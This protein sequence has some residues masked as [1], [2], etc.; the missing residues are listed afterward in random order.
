MPPNDPS[1][2]A[3]ARAERVLAEYLE[4]KAA[5]QP[6]TLETVCAENPSIAGELRELLP[7]MDAVLGELGNS[8]VVLPP[9]APHLEHD[10]DPGVS[11]EAP[12]PAAALSG[13]SLQLLER[14][15]THTP[16][17]SRYRV[18]EEVGSG[19]MGTVYR[20]WDED[21]R[22]PLA[23]KVVR[24]FNAF[25][26]ARV[27]PE[28]E[29]ALAR[30]LEEAQIT[31]QLDHPGIVPVHE[32]GL[33]D[34]GRPYFTM[35]LVRGRSL[36]EVFELVATGEEGWSETRA[37]GVLLRVCE[38][39]AFAHSKKVIHRDLKPTNVMVGKF[40]E[41][42]V[43]DWGLARV[44]GSTDRHDLRVATTSQRS[45]SLRTDR[46]E[47]RSDSADSPLFTMDGAVVGTPAY[48]PPEQARGEIEKLG[49]RSD[50]YALGAMLYHLLAG[51]MPYVPRESR[52]SNR[53][54][55]ALLIQGPPTPL[56][57][58]RE[59]VPAEIVAICEK[60]MARDP[61][62]RYGDT[63]AM[64]EDL[65]AYLEHRV[66][67][68]YETGAWA[69][70]RKWVRRNRWLA[71]SL[72][73]GVL[74]LVV[75]L[76]TALV[77]KERADESESRARDNEQLAVRRTEEVMRLSAAHDLDKLLQE[78]DELWPV[79]PELVERLQGWIERARGLV[80]QLPEHREK[81]AVLRA[82]AS[83][84][85]E[86]ERQ[87]TRERSQDL[88]DLS[89]ARAKL[90]SLRRVLRTRRD[91]TSAR[92]AEVDPSS[93]AEDW[94]ALNESAW[95]VVDP[96]NRQYGD[97]ALAMAQA[98]RAA[99]L[100]PVE[101]H[102]KILNTLAWSLL[103]LGRDGE[104]L[105]TS[106][107]A[108]A[109]ASDAT[110]GVARASHERLARAVEL[111]SKPEVIALVESEVDTLASRCLE[112]EQRTEPDRRF[113]DDAKQNAWWHDQLERLVQRLEGLEAGMLSAEGVTPWGWSMPRRLRLAERLRRGF[114]AGGEFERAW[115][116]VLP[117]I[118]ASNPRLRDLQPQVGLV[119]LG[120]DPH[121]GLW[122]F[123]DLQTGLVPERDA[124][125]QLQ[126][127]EY[128]ALVFVL[129]PG[130][131]TW[132]GAQSTNPSEKHH[133]P[134][135]GPTEI[136]QRV[137]LSPYF[138]SKYELSQGQWLR[139]SGK[140]P[141][142]YFAGKS[143]ARNRLG[144]CVDLTFPVEGVSWF[145][146]RDLGARLGLA[147]PSEAQWEH[148]ARGNT[149]S[150]WWCDEADLE[151]SANLKDLWLKAHDGPEGDDYDGWDDGWAVCAP[152]DSFAPNPF[153]L[154]HVLGN[155]WEWCEDGYVPERR[156]AGV[157]PV[158]PG[159]RDRWRVARGGSFMSRSVTAR[160]SYRATW[161]EDYRGGDC[162]VR[163]VRPIDRP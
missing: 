12:P 84:L 92:E 35:R 108:E 14:L 1:S 24:Q 89:Q 39:V 109:S 120:P 128:S 127:H 138:I 105:E 129:V 142:A 67:R 95:R 68:A 47:D 88:D 134:L 117:S 163:P 87:L 154:H 149:S 116:D 118:H 77:L 26:A 63:L 131:E 106:S 158:Q 58:L 152:V 113:P 156:L 69:E 31:G 161:P 55:L 53:T 91:D 59:D 102:Y 139:F 29:R 114:A 150:P 37:L 107:E 23:M 83:P 40:G 121:S 43:M 50:V 16:P 66:V 111:A 97:E 9:R 159:G 146:A 10:L 110:Q 85:A 153:G 17:K 137:E 101:E 112:L 151:A 141:S 78:A 61:E 103:S 123:A 136:L 41:V 60:A 21:L 44:L 8:V 96:D 135:A 6:V 74:V 147:L 100:A 99:E 48:M 57:E 115:R 80:A 144:R 38:S 140:N 30:F 28:E 94:R 86:G 160:C 51:H 65:R 82:G 145:E 19:G 162:G 56:V 7:L 11:L 90:E 72:A 75:G 20:V 130:G 13:S 98:L 2:A 71:A 73:A 93:L 18:L 46:A 36:A 76:V 25:Q 122:E 81:L 133:D 52:I 148:C 155:L 157:D 32:L 104:A 3:G 62:E 22:R 119:P 33:D 79:R 34:K 27:S 49:P 125:G 132:I 54:V 124:Q 15:S 4:R 70:A 5:G 143:E 64:A 45:A 126:I 42:L